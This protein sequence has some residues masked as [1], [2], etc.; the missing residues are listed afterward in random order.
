MEELK[1]YIE[2]LENIICRYWEKQE[3]SYDYDLCK[4]YSRYHSKY[5]TTEE[6]LEWVGTFINIPQDDDMFWD[7]DD[8]LPCGCCSCCGCTCNDEY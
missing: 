8:T 6:L 4:W 5:L 1:H 3:A 2:F 7:D